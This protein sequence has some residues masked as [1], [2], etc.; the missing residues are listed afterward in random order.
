[1]SVDSRL[2][3]ML[4]AVA[5]VR[6]KHADVM[7]SG[8][9]GGGGVS[10]DFKDS[11]NLQLAQLHGDVRHLLYGFLAGVLLLI[12]GGITAYLRLADASMATQSQITDVK[13]SQAQT[14]A[15]LDAISQRLGEQRGSAATDAR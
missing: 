6:D 2:A 4:S 5:E 8:K 13:V 10:D 9:G 7:N 12:G 15:K 1:M 11:V 3:E 14:N